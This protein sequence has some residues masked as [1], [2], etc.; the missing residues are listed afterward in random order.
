MNYL[1]NLN[2]EIKGG[3]SCHTSVNIISFIEDSPVSVFPSYY[4]Y[5]GGVY[6]REGQVYKDKTVIEKVLRNF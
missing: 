3:N 2:E 1:I 4:K 6:E 5:E